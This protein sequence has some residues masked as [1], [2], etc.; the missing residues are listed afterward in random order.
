M[1]PKITNII[2]GYIR[3]V[4]PN[5]KTNRYYAFSKRL[6]FYW[7]YIF[8]IEPFF[9]SSHIRIHFIGRGYFGAEQKESIAR[10]LADS[11]TRAIKLDCD[12][13]IISAQYDETLFQ[14]FDVC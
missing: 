14:Y 1:K 11:L 4:L 12:E 5:L 3:L 13:D 6:C 7:I 2:H 10:N 8:C 9:L